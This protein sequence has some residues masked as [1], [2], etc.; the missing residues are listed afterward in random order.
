MGELGAI[1]RKAREQA[2]HSQRDLAVKLGVPDVYP[3]RWERGVLNP[4]P[5]NLLA[6]VELYG[7]SAEAL[8]RAHVADL[9]ARARSQ[10]NGIIRR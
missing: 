7:L 9:M 10:A 8:L 4:S 1:L 5:P 6:L 3:S 2:G